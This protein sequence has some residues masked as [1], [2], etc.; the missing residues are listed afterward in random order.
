MS[1]RIIVSAETVFVALVSS[2]LDVSQKAVAVEAFSER[3][4]RSSS[5]KISIAD[6]A[7][8]PSQTDIFEARYGCFRYFLMKLELFKLKDA[9]LV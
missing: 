1:A 4:L 9:A 3:R 2:G 5:K 8:H 7:S 6:T